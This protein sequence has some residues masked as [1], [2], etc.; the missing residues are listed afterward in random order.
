[1]GVPYVGK[2][3]IHSFP[4]TLDLKLC[5]RPCIN[6]IL[7][8]SR[9]S[10]EIELIRAQQRAFLEAQQRANTTTAVTQPPTTLTPQQQR[11]NSLLE[12]VAADLSRIKASSAAQQTRAEIDLSSKVQMMSTESSLQQQLLLQQQQK[13]RVSTDME[14]S[15]QDNEQHNQS[16]V[17]IVF[18]EPQWINILKRFFYLFL[19]GDS[20]CAETL[21]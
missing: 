3:R 15:D 21:I 12:A 19:F 14:D 7:F 6:F 16:Q 20:M 8:Q 1:M 5:V 17:R 10:I 4:P 9:A 2:G 13:Q 11:S 18:F